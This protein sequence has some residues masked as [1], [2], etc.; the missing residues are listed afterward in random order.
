MKVF[1]PLHLKES[2]ED[3]LAFWMSVYSSTEA[4][5]P[6][7]IEAI[8]KIKALRSE[9]EQEKS[10]GTSNEK[11]MKVLVGKCTEVGISGDVP[12]SD[13]TEMAQDLGYW[14]TFDDSEDPA[15]SNYKEIDV[16]EFAE[17]CEYKLPKQHF[18]F[19]KKYDDSI[20]IAYNEDTDIHYIYV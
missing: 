10:S 15:D 1:K 12:W 11:E 20:Y 19:L 8:K 9:I 17:N 7:N 5:S 14:A 4:Y 18:I 3:E 2:K 6:K 16:S 13:A